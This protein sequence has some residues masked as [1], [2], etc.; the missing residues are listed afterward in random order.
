MHWRK[1]NLIKDTILKIAVG[2]AFVLVSITSPCFLHQIAKNYFKDKSKKDL[3]VRAKRLRELEKKKV[4]S[5]KELGGGKIKIELTHKGK[6]LVREYSLDNLKLN[7]PKIWD[8]KWRVI[9]YDI[10]DYHKKARDAFRH[11][12]R[13]MGLYPIQKSVWVSPYDCMPE[14][15]FL[16]AIFDININSHVY[17][18]ITT[19]IPGERAIKKWFDIK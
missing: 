14:I 1:N 15:E 5:F 8:K 12:I 13:E 9:M 19:S 18:I 17:Q 2:G 3:Y 6:L 4:I 11:K 10:P 7:K 16:C